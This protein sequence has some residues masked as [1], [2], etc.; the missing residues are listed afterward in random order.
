MLLPSGSAFSLMVSAVEYGR[1]DAAIHVSGLQFNSRNVGSDCVSM[2]W[3]A[4]SARRYRGG[5]AEKEI[6]DSDLRVGPP[7]RQL[8]RLSF[9]V[10]RERGL[11]VETNHN[12][13][14]GAGHA[15]GH[16]EENADRERERNMGIRGIRP[17]RG[18]RG[19]G[20]KRFPSRQQHPNN[21]PTFVLRISGTSSYSL[22]VH[23]K[24][25]LSFG[26]SVS[27]RCVHPPPPLSGEALAFFVAP[28]SCCC[29][30]GCARRR[31][32]LEAVE[33]RERRRAKDASGVE[34]EFMTTR[35]DNI[36]ARGNLLSRGRGAESFDGHRVNH[37]PRC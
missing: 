4:V 5:G 33:G 24:M 3:R 20:A 16:A 15:A 2:T 30:E 9:K 32:C 1:P 27:T 23:M 14:K 12:R 29:E 17:P 28:I 37:F 31:R 10:A 34:E 36:K 21:S 22:L 13:L 6:D 19:P 26:A 8:R 35:W 25:P 7:T 11:G 18:P